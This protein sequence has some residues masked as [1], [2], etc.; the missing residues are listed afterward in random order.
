MAARARRPGMITSSLAPAFRSG[1][2]RLNG[3]SSRPSTTC[4]RRLKGKRRIK[5]AA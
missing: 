4:M 5:T 2:A 1:S 3:C